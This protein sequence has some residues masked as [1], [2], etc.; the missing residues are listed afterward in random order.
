MNKITKQ[1]R[2]PVK[3]QHL[4]SLAQAGVRFFKS[5]TKYGRVKE[6]YLS[7]KLKREWVALYIWEYRY[8]TK[9][10]CGYAKEQ[11]L[12]RRII[13]S[14]RYFPEDLKPDW[15]K[16]RIYFKDGENQCYLSRQISVVTG[17]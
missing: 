17:D 5:S 15:I 7:G 3:S 12:N 10:Y 9:F 4:V 1:S 6:L 2:K 16:Q 13:S 8:C 14:K 11:C